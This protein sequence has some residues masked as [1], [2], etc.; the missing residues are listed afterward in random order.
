M[1]LKVKSHENLDDKTIRKVIKQLDKDVPITKVEACKLLNISYNTTR[2]N[3]ILSSY[4]EKRKNRSRLMSRNRGLAW[5]AQDS[6]YLII[7]Y[8]TGRALADL[9][10]ILYRSTLA[11][12]LRLKEL[13]I[14]LHDYS[15]TYMKPSLLDEGHI[16]EDIENG[17]IVWSARYNCVCEIVDK[18]GSNNYLLWLLGSHRQFAFQPWYE[19]GYMPAMKEYNITAKDFKEEIC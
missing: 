13:K 4:T 7:E 10:E 17:S 1:R 18:R 12:K 3:N 11:L 8:L 6:K 5:T 15:T 16:V 2:L 9:K 19:L 14:P